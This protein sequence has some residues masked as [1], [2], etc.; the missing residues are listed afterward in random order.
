MARDRSVL[1]G[2]LYKSDVASA[3]LARASVATAVL[4]VATVVLPGATVLARVSDTALAT[5][6]SGEQLVTDLP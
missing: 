1:T 2:N 5:A 4:P 6:T 3:L